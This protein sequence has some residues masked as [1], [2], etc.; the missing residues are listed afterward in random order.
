MCEAGQ[1]PA[2]SYLELEQALARS[3]SA[4]R[5]AEEK[6]VREMEMRASDAVAHLTIA[7]ECA[8]SGVTLSKHMST[9]EA[10]RAVIAAI[11]S[12][13]A[14]RE[15]AERELASLATDR[16][17]WVEQADQRAAEAVEYLGRATAA[18]SRAAEA[19]RTRDVIGEHYALEIKALHAA[20]SHA[21]RAEAALRDLVE[22]APHEAEIGDCCAWC[23]AR[24]AL[25]RQ[26]VGR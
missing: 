2:Q 17:S 1:K 4:R 21:A 8:G 16:D 14:A 15:K 11:A 7:A 5:E 13:R 6:L 18:E 10:V 25:A 9:H 24:A 26:E 23:R 20:E 12:E 3:E 19:E 22:K